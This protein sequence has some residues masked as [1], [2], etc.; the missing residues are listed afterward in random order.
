MS[1]EKFEFKETEAFKPYRLK[2]EQ[3]YHAIILVPES[4][5]DKEYFDMIND[6]T[7]GGL[8]WLTYHYALD[9]NISTDETAKLAERDVEIIN[10]PETQKKV[11]ELHE[12]WKKLKQEE[13]EMDD[14]SPFWGEWHEENENKKQQIMFEFDDILK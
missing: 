9:H 12:R 11:R 8:D 6:I 4:D 13:L 3:G 7:G 1:E 10:R 14:D 2:V 5:R